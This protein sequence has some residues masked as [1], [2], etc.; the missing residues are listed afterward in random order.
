[1]IECIHNKFILNNEVVNCNKFTGNYLTKGISVYEV[2]RII[3]GKPLFV[4]DHYKRLI[5]S[6]NI[7][8]LKREVSIDELTNMNYRLIE[9]NEIQDGN[10]KFLINYRN[11]N[12]VN[13]L[14]YYIKHSYPSEN[15]YKNGIKTI[16]Y[17]GERVNPNAKAVLYNL[18]QSI[19]REIEKKNLREVILIDRKGYI[20]EG[21]RSNIF[22]VLNDQVFTPP[23]SGILEGITRKYV[24]IICNEHKIPFIEKN[25]KID[26]LKKF[27]SAFISGTSSKILPLNQIQNI[28]YTVNSSVLRKIMK[29]YDLKISEYLSHL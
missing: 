18:R 1:M 15:E 5:N 17:K 28:K 25:I 20:T 22:F 10:C 8:K 16:L 23:K 11:K 3:N 9:S 27:E 6:L 24:E 14:C 12:Q 13:I 19:D 7:L 2:I 21:S 29:E 4:E 26:D